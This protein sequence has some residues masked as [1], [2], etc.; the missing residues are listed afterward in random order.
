MLINACNMEYPLRKPNC[1]IK[2]K[3]SLLPFLTIGVIWAIFNKSGNIPI[4][5]ESL[6]SSESQT[7]KKML[8]HFNVDIGILFGPADLFV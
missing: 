6:M 2:N 5:K 1:L 3:S 7:E 4:S 8:K